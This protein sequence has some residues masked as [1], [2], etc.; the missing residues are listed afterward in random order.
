MKIYSCTI[1]YEQTGNMVDGEYVGSEQKKKIWVRA[2]NVISAY[3]R[4]LHYRE[5]GEVKKVYEVLSVELQGVIDK[6]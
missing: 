6:D 2:K 3:N 4:A 5:A 1:S